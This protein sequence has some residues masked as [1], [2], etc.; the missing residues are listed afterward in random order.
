MRDIAKYAGQAIVLLA[1]VA[2][3]GFLASS[4]A[5]QHFPEGQALIKMTFVHGGQ[6]VG[7][8][9]RRTAAEL[10]EMAAN[11]RRLMDCP[12]DR[13]PVVIELDV[14]GQRVHREVI[15]ASGLHGD[16]P[17]VYYDSFQVAAGAHS[18]AVRLR[19]TDREEG[20]DYEGS[21]EFVL[22]PSQ[23]LVVQFRPEAGGFVFR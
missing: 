5:Y 6:H 2:G 23:L 12:R 11:M 1:L 21:A 18:I 10:E 15:A 20:F 8:C 22:E 19:D 7:G 9:R 17:A 4:P 13:L 3:V 16:G 14:D